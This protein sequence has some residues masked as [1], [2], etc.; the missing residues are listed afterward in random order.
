M[1]P[2]LYRM[3]QR[4]AWAVRGRN[5]Y[6]RYTLSATGYGVILRADLRLLEFCVFSAILLCLQGMISTLVW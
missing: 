5:E 1:I 4:G 3:S 6:K 2:V